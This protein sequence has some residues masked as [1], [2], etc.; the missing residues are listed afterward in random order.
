MPLPLPP[1]PLQQ[2]NTG[3]CAATGRYDGGARVLHLPFS[4]VMAKLCHCFV[5]EAVPVRAS[6]GQLTAV[7][8]HREVTVEGDAPAAVEPVLRFA[9][10]TETERFDPR[11]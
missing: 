10:A 7:R 9:D 4:C 3:R 6:F 1:V 11:D 5:D 2:E 8:V